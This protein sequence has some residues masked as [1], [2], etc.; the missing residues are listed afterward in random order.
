VIPDSQRKTYKEI[1]AQWEDGGHG[2][3]IQRLVPRI[4]ELITA[5]NQR[6]GLLE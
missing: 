1:V 5:F 6:M 3:E 4:N 2:F